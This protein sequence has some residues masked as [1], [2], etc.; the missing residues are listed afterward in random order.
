MKKRAAR[1]D[2]TFGNRFGKCDEFALG[3][4]HVALMIRF[5]KYWAPP[6]LWAILISYFSTDFFS[7]TKTAS[8]LDP[9]LHWLFPAMSAEGREWINAAVRKLG[10]WTEFFVFALFLARAFRSSTR[11]SL[12]LRWALWTLLIIGFYAGA[13]EIHQ[14]FVISRTASVKDSLL[15]FFGGCC[16]VFMI[17]AQLKTPPENKPS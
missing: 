1:P 10:H 16:A 9:W 6:L 13:D 14:L 12:R 11:A 7:F 2:I 17:F 5:L 15:D 8:Y 4:L 3:F